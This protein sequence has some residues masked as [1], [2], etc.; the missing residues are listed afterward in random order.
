[1]TLTHAQRDAIAA[2]SEAQMAAKDER[3]LLLE[4]Q[5]AAQAL[6]PIV[7]AAAALP[8]PAAAAADIKGVRLP[9]FWS[10]DPLL[11]FEQAEAAFE[12]CLV[13]NSR[14]KYNLV[15]ARLAPMTAKSCR[16]LIIAIRAAAPADPYEQLRDHLIRCYGRT[17]WQ[18]GFAILDSPAIGDRRPSD[19]LQDMRAL[20]PSDGAENTLFKCLFLRRLPAPIRDHLLAVG[21]LPMDAMAVIADRLHDSMPAA[22][23]AFSVVEPDPEVN[24]VKSVR[25]DGRRSQGG[26]TRGA[27]RGGGGGRGGGSTKTKKRVFCA[28]HH[29]FGV[30]CK[31]CIKP[32]DWRSGN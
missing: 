20:Q 1:M 30:D 22:A 31:V 18:L 12:S 17:D 4:R 3:I 15:L 25:S 27:G 8:P 26:G 6:Q 9:E 2:E 14:A 10:E 16:S 19:L 29:N 11:W 28:N 32:C 13:T 24:A 5:L 21:V 7:H 23:A